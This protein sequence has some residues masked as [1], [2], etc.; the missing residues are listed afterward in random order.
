[1]GW[2]SKTKVFRELISGRNMKGLLKLAKNTMK[3]SD[4]SSRS[5]CFNS[6]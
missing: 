2:S 6:D 5:L 3:R 1:M 4:L